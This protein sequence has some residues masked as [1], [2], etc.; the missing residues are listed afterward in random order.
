[1]PI[2]SHLLRKLQD[3]LGQEAAEDFVTWMEQTDSLRGDVAELRHEMQIG[4]TR[5]EAKLDRQIAE[6]KAEMIKWM[7]LFWAGTA[8]AGLLFRR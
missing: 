1:M 5:I 2:S 8:L 7:L 3:A 4:F 6:L